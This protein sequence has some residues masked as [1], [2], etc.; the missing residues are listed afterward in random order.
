M[1]TKN[2]FLLFFLIAWL[3]CS[4]LVKA[5]TL[6]AN[7]GPYK[8]IFSANGASSTLIHY[9]KS[10]MSWDSVRELTEINKI[11][12]A[13]AYPYISP[14]GLRLYFT[15]DIGSNNLYCASRN[16]INSF[17]S[18][19]Q[20]LSTNFPSG[21]FSCWL[22][23]DELEIFYL[24]NGSLYYSTRS[25]IINP[26]SV[27]VSINLVGNIQDFISGPSLTPDKQELYL[28][29]STMNNDYIFK[30]IKTGTL[31]Y[32]LNDT[33]D[34]PTGFTA[35]PGQLSKDGLK[36]FLALTDALNS[37]KLYQLDRPNTS[38]PFSNPTILDTNINNAILIN[39]QPSVTSGENIIVWVRNDAN[40]WSGNDLYIA[41]NNSAGISTDK[42][43]LI[44]CPEV[45]PNPC[46]NDTKIKFRLNHNGI[47]NF[48]LLDISGRTLLM[49]NNNYDM[50]IHQETLDLNK[51]CPGVYFLKIEI[52]NSLKTVKLVKTD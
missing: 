11:D 19:K 52:E 40:T 41:I 22:T 48:K 12:T 17:F 34:V 10:T 29:G 42:N 39:S 23:N 4:N 3:S 36:Y 38:V 6:D 30:F 8:P 43:Y 35:G 16:N 50:G 18:N 46:F 14:D 2:L 45:F 47:V 27:P 32:T 5:Q 49:F 28:F 26:F 7:G 33:L 20:L 15:E 37:K 9:P 21:S 24:N 31:T 1:K 51:I 25:S 13:D 44:D